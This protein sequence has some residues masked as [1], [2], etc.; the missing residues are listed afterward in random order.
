MYIYSANKRRGDKGEKEDEGTWGCESVA[1]MTGMLVE[2]CAD[3]PARA[4]RVDMS[5]VRQCCRSG[6]SVKVG[7]APFKEVQAASGR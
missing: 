3:R 1:L 5:P 4:Q 2:G 6:C 7:L